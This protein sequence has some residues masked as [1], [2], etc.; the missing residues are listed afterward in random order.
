MLGGVKK[1]LLVDSGIMPKDQASSDRFLLVENGLRTEPLPKRF[2]CRKV[3]TGRKWPKEWAS[4]EK[5][6]TGRKWHNA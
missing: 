6:S 1:F 3:S 5:V 4:A 2:Y